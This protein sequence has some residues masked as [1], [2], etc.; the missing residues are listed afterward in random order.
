MTA[1]DV[2]TSIPSSA[3]KTPVSGGQECYLLTS[4]SIGGRREG[5]SYLPA[6]THLRVGFVL[7]VE[8]V[9]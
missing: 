4:T 3:Y 9:N 2:S 5:M 8:E 6:T 1:T 7:E